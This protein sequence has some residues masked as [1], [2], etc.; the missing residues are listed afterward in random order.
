MI[1]VRNGWYFCGGNDVENLFEILN[2][3]IDCI[4][5][6]D[7]SLYHLEALEMVSL[8]LRYRNRR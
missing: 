4:G 8:V 1:P 3:R 2:F 7:Y 6:F 5:Q